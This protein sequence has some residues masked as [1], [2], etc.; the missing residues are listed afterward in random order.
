M[1]AGPSRGDRSNR[2]R[3]SSARSPRRLRGALL[4]PEISAEN[5]K[6]LP[7]L[8]ARRP[9]PRETGC[10]R[11]RENL[12]EPALAPPRRHRARTPRR[13]RQPRE[14]PARAG[15]ARSR[16]IAVRLALGAARG[17]ILRQSSA[18]CF[19]LSAAGAVVGFGARARAQ[20]VRSSRSS[21]GRRPPFVDAGV[22]CVCLRLRRG[23]RRFLTCFLFGF[24][25]ALR[26]RDRARRR[27]L[28]RGGRGRPGAATARASGARSSFRRSR[29]RSSSWP[30]RS[31]SPEV[32]AGFSPP[33]R[34]CGSRAC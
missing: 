5:A 6:R 4:A 24:A 33:T 13:V 22:D 14:P 23:R 15:S 12:R 30:P 1:S 21:H 25:P 11:L 32:W 17:R 18:E 16:E 26:A 19:V 28:G 2:R 10:R 29:S 9:Y 27:S 20:R 8:H 34:A 7:R 3:P 31:F